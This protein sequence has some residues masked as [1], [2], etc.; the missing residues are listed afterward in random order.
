MEAATIKANSIIDQS[1]KFGLGL[2]K[3]HGQG[4]DGTIRW[5]EKIMASIRRKNPKATNLYCALLRLNLVGN[6]LNYVVNVRNTCGT[7]KA[8]I[9]YFRDKTQEVNS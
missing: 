3:M 9:K 6:D 5:L 1:Q 7:I 2:D 8:N 4:Y